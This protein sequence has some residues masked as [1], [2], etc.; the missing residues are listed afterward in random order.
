MERKYLGNKYTH[1]P[2]INLLTGQG[3]ISLLFS[4]Q[5]KQNNYNNNNKIYYLY[6][7]KDSQ[8]IKISLKEVK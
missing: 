8:L 1:K 3:H 2:L 5:K 7:T 6:S 4:H